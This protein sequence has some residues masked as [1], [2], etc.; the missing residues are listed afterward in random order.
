MEKWAR[1][2]ARKWSASTPLSYLWMMVGQVPSSD[3]RAYANAIYDVPTQR[4]WVSEHKILF[5][6]QLEYYMHRLGPLYIIPKLR[7]L[8]S[9]TN[10]VLPC[11]SPLKKQTKDTRLEESF[12]L[13]W[14]RCGT[15][16]PSWGA[17]RKAV[18]P[19]NQD[20]NHVTQQG[21]DVTFY[22]TAVYGP[23]WDHDDS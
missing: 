15:V 12:F 7:I 14:E 18:W 10:H 8:I 21:V 1:K 20:L 11:I 17:K 9:S 3:T 4:G 16:T 23:S 2:Q 5:V 13:Q 19:P 22:L 6:R